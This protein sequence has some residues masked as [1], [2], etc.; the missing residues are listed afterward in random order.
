MPTVRK[1]P[2]YAE[3]LLVAALI[4]LAALARWVGWREKTWDMNLFF[5]WYNQLKAEGG[6]RGLDTEI[7]NYNAPF[8]YCLAVVVYLP[9]PLILKIK[10][11]WILFD[12]LLAFFTYRIVALRWPGRRIATVTAL[13][14]V[15]LPTV[16]LNAS[17]LGQADAMWASFALGG[18]YY[19][20][21]GSP[22]WGVA[23][24]GV[25]FAFK[26]QGVFLFP[27]LLLL[28]LSG[29]IRWRTLLAAPAAFLVLDIPAL[30]IGRDPV[31]L[32]SIYDMD[33]QGR[34][35][36]ALTYRAASVYNF[37]P[38]VVRVDTVRTLGYVFTAAMVLG[39]CYVLV[40]RA[41]E[42]TRT[43]IL[44]AATLFSIMVP[45]LLPGMHERYFFLADVLTVVLAVHLPRLWFVPLLVQA[46]SLLSYEDYLFGRSPLLLPMVVPAALMLA[47]LLVVGHR[48][49]T[50][51]LTGP[52]DRPVRRE[53]APARTG[54]SARDRRPRYTSRRRPVPP[55]R[56]AGT[57]PAAS[58][59]R[60]PAR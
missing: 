9:G 32:L 54:T 26:P 52:A 13:V 43:R 19:L 49:L 24:C 45:F 5:Q 40:V 31:E 3:I 21:R 48:L 55:V 41:L 27:L 2:P 56:R 35:V 1:L 22:W 60:A 42:M 29:T 59:A 38:A 34:I 14:T 18:V 8:L 46:A 30:L 16:V 7:G 12:V 47:A 57:P 50:D 36:E 15:L 17:V 4:G 6:W 37:V 11:V 39:V 44:L 51:G 33:R 23:L 25:S 20:L 58:P 53:S 10:A 28:A